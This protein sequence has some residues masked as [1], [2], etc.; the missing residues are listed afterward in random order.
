MQPDS[1]T[2]ILVSSSW[3]SD[4]V[5]PQ[6]QF[7]EKKRC[8]NFLSLR[9]KLHGSLWIDAKF[10][11]AASSDV[12]FTGLGFLHALS[13]FDCYAQWL[14]G[15]ARTASLYIVVWRRLIRYTVGRNKSR[16]IQLFVFIRQILLS[17]FFVASNFIFSSNEKDVKNRF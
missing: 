7:F 5:A 10:T 1:R 8:N 13:V 4:T 9:F 11:S 14:S 6:N 3:L 16:P 12:H 17:F 15:Q 2:K